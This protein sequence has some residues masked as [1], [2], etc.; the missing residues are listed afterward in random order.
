MLINSDFVTNERE[1]FERLWYSGLAT[2]IHIHLQFSPLSASK[3][4]QGTEAN[5]QLSI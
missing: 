4:E 2:V 3:W 1:I 5:S